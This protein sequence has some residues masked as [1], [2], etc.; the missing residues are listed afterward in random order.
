MMQALIVAAI[1]A[2]AFWV[3]AKRYAPKPVRRLTYALL[4]RGAKRLGWKQGVRKFESEISTPSSAS[5]GDG[6]GSCG[7]CS[8]ADGTPAAKQNTITPEALKLTIRR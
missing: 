4:A 5:C 1:V 8:P 2:Y 3:V 6:C 7:A